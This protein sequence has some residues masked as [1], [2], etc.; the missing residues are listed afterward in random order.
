VTNERALVKAGYEVITAED[1]ESALQSAK[2]QKPD[3]ILLDLLLP[4]V[5]GLEVLARLKHNRDTAKIPVVAV[6]GLSEK[7]RQRLIDA[8]AED[9]LEKSSV[10]TDKGQNRLPQVLEGVIC[11]IN[12]KR[13]IPFSPLLDKK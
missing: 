1:G 2:E 3:L 12:R 7:N 8:G 9:Y 4:K 13:G 6:S 5:S 10:F 11:R